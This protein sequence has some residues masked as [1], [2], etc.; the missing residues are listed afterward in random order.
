MEKEKILFKIQKEAGTIP[1]DSVCNSCRS[2]IAISDA[3][4]LFPLCKATQQDI[5]EI[6]DS[7]DPNN[8]KQDNNELLN[9]CQ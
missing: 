5:R 4:A 6:L 3:L 1:L 9:R 7:R 2:F 8:C